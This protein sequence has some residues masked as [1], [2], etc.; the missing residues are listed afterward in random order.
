MLIK[1]LDTFLKKEIE[2]VVAEYDHNKTLRDASILKELLKKLEQF[3]ANSGPIPEKYG[4]MELDY[5]TTGLVLQKVAQYW[6]SLWG[7]CLV[8]TVCARFILEIDDESIKEKYLPK[9]CSG[10]MIPCV[11]ITE[12]NVGSNPAFIET[13]LEK[14]D[15]GYV[16]DGSKTW[17]SNGSVS[18]IA[19]I[20]ASTDRSLGARGLA[21]VLVDRKKSP[22]Q[23]KELEKMG[24]KSFPTSELFFDNVFVPEQNL[25][26]PPGGGLKMTLR[27]FELARSLMACASVGY[28]RAAI[29]LAVKYAR[30]R[31]QFGKKI[32]S[33]QMIQEMIADMRARTDAAELLVRRALW[34]MDQKIRCDTESALAKAYATEAAVK[35]TKD[36]IQIMGGYGLS[37]EYPAERYYRDASSMTIPDGTTQIQKLIVARDM[38]GIDAFV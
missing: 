33:F 20:I 7:I 22:Y 2:P 9:I 36:C 38:L 10:D 35:T 8:M 11:G 5:L 23:V 18:D 14:T 3:G 32:G 15:G 16:L 24:L 25:I 13:T 37:E 31:E 17:I 30:Q 28:S 29:A 4:G 6:G 27:T 34:M 26:V 12:P 21:G 19:I 1:E